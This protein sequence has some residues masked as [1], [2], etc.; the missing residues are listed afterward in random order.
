MAERL[1]LG[2]G[3]ELEEYR[4]DAGELR[5]YMVTGPASPHCTRGAGADRCGGL[6][7][8]KPFGSRAVWNI[9]QEQPLTLTPSIQCECSAAGTH[10]QHGWVQN[11]RWV[12]AGGVVA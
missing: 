9:D 3:Y 12:N 2:C 11:G 5:G 1:D 7:P 8:T 6:V 10:G 4:N